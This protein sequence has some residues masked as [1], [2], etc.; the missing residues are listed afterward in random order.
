MGVGRMLDGGGGVKAGQVI[1]KT[2]D[3]GWHAIEDRV[4]VHDFHAT[5][6]RLFGLDH[7]KLTYPFKGLDVRLTNQGGNVV[8]KV[9]A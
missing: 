4:H 8:E 5:L 1:G 9:F 6:L 2:D 7:L 3:F